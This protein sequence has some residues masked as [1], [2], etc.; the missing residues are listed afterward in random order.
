M[1]SREWWS[2][3]AMQ[4]PVSDVALLYYLL[5]KHSI[6]PSLQFLFHF[7]LLLRDQL[8]P[9]FLYQCL[10]IILRVCMMYKWHRNEKDTTPSNSLPHHLMSCLNRVLYLPPEWLSPISDEYVANI[11]PFL[12]LPFSFP[13]IFAYLNCKTTHVF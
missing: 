6:K 5:R 9:E 8:L 3:L 1:T 2:V 10:E 13:D 12:T 11:T 7:G 4:A